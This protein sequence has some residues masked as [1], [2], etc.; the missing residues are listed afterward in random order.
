[1]NYN[2]QE[3][4][5]TKFP[6]LLTELADPPKKLYSIGCDLKD[7]T[8]PVA[9]VGSRKPTQYGKDMTYRLAYDLAKVGCTVIS[10]LALGIDSIAHRAVLDA[11]GKTIAVL[12]N[13]LDRIYPACHTQLAKEI[14]NNNGAIVS[15][16]PKGASTLKYHFLARNRIISGL[17]LGTIITEATQKSG[18][19][20]TA[21]MALEQNRVVMAVPGNATSPLSVGTNNLIRMGASLVSTAD[22]IIEALGLLVTLPTANKKIIADSPDEGM[23]IKILLDRPRDADELSKMVEF[24]IAW[25]NRVLTMLEIKGV[26][27][28][29]GGGKWILR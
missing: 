23:I 3:Y 10:G 15:E 27:A 13:G 21:R 17:S 16:N 12:A 6:N 24:D 22:D 4:K 20:T 1:M 11:G 8:N 5:S 18:S 29:A 28:C 14:I 26:V 9:V 19:L 7:I 25:V 2:I